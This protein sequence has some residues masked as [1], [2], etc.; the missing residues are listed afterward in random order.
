MDSN[1]SKDDSHVIREQELE[2][3]VQGLQESENALKL[4]VRQ[5]GIVADLG[6]RALAG[7]DLNA[8]MDEA[9]QLVAQT[10]EVEYCNIMELLPGESGLI[11]RAGYGWQQGYFENVTVA[12]GLASLSGYALQAHEPLIV[13]DLSTER[14]FDRPFYLTQHGVVSGI[15]MVIQGHEKPF[16]VL[17]AFTTRK[18]IFNR[19]EMNFLQ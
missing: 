1:Y 12:S 11:L 18:K 7:A 5:R 17:G 2:T 13:E 8:L 3:V 14:R 19:D 16:G 6:Q 10:L 15:S 9:A 4:R